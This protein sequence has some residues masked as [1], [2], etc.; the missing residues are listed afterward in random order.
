MAWR[1]LSGMMGVPLEAPLKAVLAVLGKELR[2]AFRDANVL[3]YSVA[4][5][6]LLYPLLLWGAVQ[7]LVLQQGAVEQQAPRVEVHGSPE[8]MSAL[9]EDPAVPGEGGREALLEGS[10][11]VLVEADVEDGP[12]TVAFRSTRGRSERARDLV[13][14]RLDHQRDL[15]FEALALDAGMPTDAL[16]PWP[17]A[18][19]DDAGEDRVVLDAL[20]RVLPLMAL[21]TLIISIIYPMVEVITGERERGTLETTMVAAVPRWAV[22]AGKLLCASIT[23]VLAMA[24]NALAIWATL[25][26][27]LAEAEGPLVELSRV[28]TPAVGL[29]LLALV[30]L[31]P[32]VAAW[33]GLVLLP[34][35]SFESG[36]NRGTLVMTLCLALAV[37]CMLAGLEPGWAWAWV[38]VGGT[39]MGLRGAIT[40]EL[41]LGPIAL[42]SVVNLALAGLGMLL[43]GRVLSRE[44]YLF[45]HATPRWLAWLERGR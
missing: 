32:A 37:P 5:P 9:L 25:S 28:A 4:F 6:L 21:M 26:S 3:L 12:V 18:L 19:V 43:G 1:R 45:G 8:L 17:I 42:A 44:D 20:A 29:A 10:L 41:G 14:E 2:E 13:E 16:C 36:Q 23:G 40:G 31:A 22:V 15:A 39:A 33:M 38:P 30:L 34:A 35:R 11:D 7:L 24:G 27:L